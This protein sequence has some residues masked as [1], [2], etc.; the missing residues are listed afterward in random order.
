MKLSQLRD[1]RWLLEIPA[2]ADL[3]VLSPF[4]LAQLADLIEDALT[5]ETS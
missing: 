5:E 2:R 4:E 3:I 1:G